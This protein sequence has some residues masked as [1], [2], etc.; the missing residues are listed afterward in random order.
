MLN[1]VT[2][3]KTTGLRPKVFCR[4]EKEKVEPVK[5]KLKKAT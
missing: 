3:L 1:I 4:E 5:K 2:S